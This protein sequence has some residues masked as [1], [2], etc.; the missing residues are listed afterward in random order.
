MLVSRNS[1]SKVTRNIVGFRFYQPTL[2]IYKSIL[3]FERIAQS[4]SHYCYHW[5]YIDK[6]ISTCFRV[7]FCFD[8]KS[9]SNDLGPRRACLCCHCAQHSNL[10]FEFHFQPYFGEVAWKAGK[11]KCRVRTGFNLNLI[12]TGIMGS[13][14][15]NHTSW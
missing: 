1:N 7:V 11:C 6:I 14:T 12:L 9:T 3:M 4:S 10:C 13:A 2:K 15:W 5:F 8:F